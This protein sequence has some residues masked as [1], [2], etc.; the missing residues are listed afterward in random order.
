MPIGFR[1]IIFLAVLIMRSQLGF[2][3][4]KP[5]EFDVIIIGAGVMGSAAAYNLGLKG[6]AKVLVLERTDDAK[7]A[8]G[9]ST[10]ASRIT[11]K[12]SVEN[13]EYMS[14]NQRSFQLLYELEEKLGTE[15]IEPREF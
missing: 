12:I 13:P 8:M 14:L 1:P 5:N 11:R 3:Q 10:G 6:K 7:K 4:L 9:S 2:A 15:L